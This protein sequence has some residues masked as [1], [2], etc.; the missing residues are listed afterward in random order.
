M[1]ARED[2]SNSLIHFTKGANCNEAFDNLLSIIRMKRINGNS[3]NI[4]GTFKCIC[5]S[6]TPP[7]FLTAGL[8]NENYYSKYSPFGIMVSKEYL[9]ALGGRPVIYETDSEYESLSYTHK[10]R[11]VLYDLNLKPPIDFTWEKEWRIKAEYLEINN[12][13]I[14]IIVLNE[15]WKDALINAYRDDLFQYYYQIFADET[16]S[17]HAYYEDFPWEILLLSSE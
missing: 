1:K 14:K 9:F 11:H 6:E 2:I 7:R 16:V 12:E 17:L 4:K 13:N 8:I 5:F 10:W 3:R 15:L